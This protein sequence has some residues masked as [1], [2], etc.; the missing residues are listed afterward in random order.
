M[1]PPVLQA[2]L[3]DQLEIYD[4]HVCP[5]SGGMINQAV[6]IE[7][8]HGRLFLKWHAAAPAGMFSAEARGLDL[9]RNTQTVQ[10][11]EVILVHEPGQGPAA[12][13]LEYLDPA[14]PASGWEAQFGY[15]LAALHRHQDPSQQYGLDHPNFIGRLPQPNDPHSQWADFYRDCRLLPQMNLARE[16]GRLN[17]TR[18]RLLETVVA[19]LE[20]LLGDLPPCPSLL[21]GDLWSGNLV[22]SVQGAAVVDPAVYY[23]EREMELAFMQLFNGFSDAVFGAY[24]QEFPLTP[25]YE[26][27]RPLHQIYPLLVHLNHFGEEYGPWLET[28]CRTAVGS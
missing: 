22:H 6:R 10:V 28:A 5:E 19:N 7:S 12:L 9:L 23:G 11:P 25:G 15:D 2:V 13:V 26:R 3:R 8:E 20:R 27:R 17:P 21:H 24:Q 14:R 16:Q 18:E 4:F 1:L